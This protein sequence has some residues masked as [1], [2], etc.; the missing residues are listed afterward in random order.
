MVRLQLRQLLSKMLSM[1]AF[2]KIILETDNHTNATCL[3]SS[4]LPLC[5]MTL[6]VFLM[7]IE[8]DIWWCFTP[9]TE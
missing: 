8:G 2:S 1:N 6:L 9:H 5:M 3:L 4:L 7:E